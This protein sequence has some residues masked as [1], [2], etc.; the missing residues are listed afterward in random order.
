MNPEKHRRL[1]R[2]QRERK[3]DRSS[4]PVHH[5]RREYNK[6]YHD[7]YK[8]LL[9][10]TF[11]ILI[12]SLLVIGYTYYKTGDV[13]Y[14]GVSLSGGITL[15]VST[16]GL[17]ATDIH[18]LEDQLREQFPENDV[19][20]REINDF[21][22]QQGYTIEAT[23]HDKTSGSLEDL[24]QEIL[25]S[26]NVPNSEER[27]SIEVTGP[28]LG[29]SFFEQTVKAVLIAFAFMG[30]VVFIYFG[31]TLNQKIITGILTF[32]AAILIW[33]SGGWF[34]T[35]LAVIAGAALIY[36]YI[37]YSIP[38]TAVILAAFSTITFTIAILDLAQMRISTAGI[39]AFLM[40]I[41]YSVDTD[42]LLSTRVLKSTSGTVYE[43]IVST[44]RTG[45]TM[46][47]TTFA[48]AVLSLL[49][50][51]SEVIREIM[52]IIA[53]GIIGDVFFTWI[54]NSGI[55]RLYLERKGRK[56]DDA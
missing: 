7:Y 48:V 17:P 46:T 9:F 38:S 26:L 52:I 5:V 11:G 54:Q 8:H 32:I 14:K 12:L 44:M 51:Q 37:K 6:I 15:S 20:I 41:G 29:A 18:A 16:Q 53:I 10:V 45:I 1:L 4:E 56:S 36:L 2:E 24:A 19:I 43:R 33:S 23:T 40:L 31:E 28:S 55:L 50:S 27:V 39:G 47:S 42:I 25:V 3:V 21:G 49:L 34:M 30:F 13:I 35:T 22:V